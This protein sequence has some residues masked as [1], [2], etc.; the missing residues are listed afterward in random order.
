MYVPV[1]ANAE[2]DTAGA[3]ARW[4]WPTLA[5]IV[6]VGAVLRAVAQAEYFAKHPLATHLILDAATYW[7][8]AGR[9]AGGE[10]VGREPFFS[11]PLYPYLLGLWRALGG[12][13][14]GVASGQMLLDLVTAVLIAW[15]ARRRFNATVGLLAAGLFVLMR[16]PASYALRVLTSS[17]QL[18]LVCLAWW[19]L[20][21]VLEK[22]RWQRAALAGGALGLL[23]LA[24]PP[25][26]LAIPLAAIWVWWLAGWRP[27]KLVTAAVVVLAGGLVIA[28]ATLHNLLACGEFIPISAQAGVTF[29]QGN[30]ERADGTYTALPDVSRIRATQNRDAMNAYVAATGGPPSWRGVNRYFYERGLAYWR[31]QPLGAA[32]LL[33][34]KA[35]RFV[36]GRHTGDIF[37]PTAE[38]REGLLSRLSLLPVRTAWLIPPA[39]VMLAVCTA[40]PR[41]WF[42]EL[43]LFG[44]P[45]LVVVL[46][47]Y[48][49][50]YRYPALPILAVAAAG[51]LWQAAQWR[52]QRTWTVAVVAAVLLA[53][54]LGAINNARD[55]DDLKAG[56]GRLY[57][58]LAWAA[59][60]EGR[61]DNAVRWYQR[62]LE[63]VPDHALAESELGAALLLLGRPA[64]AEAHLRHAIVLDPTDATAHNRLGRALAGQNRL[65]DALPLFEQAVRLQPQA[66]ELHLDL[67]VTLRRLGDSDGALQALRTAVSLDPNLRRA[68][69]YLD[70][71]LAERGDTGP[72]P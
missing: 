70:Q 4:F 2:R 39:L 60:E 56:R 17:L 69:E 7:E 38:I 5:L 54:V 31:A 64:E 24:F 27:A 46:F 19:A 43:L 61:W 53:L 3:A 37:A 40:R 11:A 22:P 71:L 65:A 16:E 12:G 67:A 1:V 26:I 32:R 48:S 20:V 30:S 49:P 14:R 36:T 35:Y 68:R 42:P 58:G 15:I 6:A 55:F 50:R 10:I 63:L 21:G 47:W 44:L 66:A 52:T 34:I 62:V 25:A 13:L 51:A 29:A 28:P 59:T 41:Q 18:P 45:L 33:A 72:R 57:F 9:I 23:A 8:W